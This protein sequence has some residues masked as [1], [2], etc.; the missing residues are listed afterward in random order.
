MRW[1]VLQCALT[2]HRTRRG[3]CASSSPDCR[4][5]R[6]TEHWSHDARSSSFYKALFA[7]TSAQIKVKTLIILYIGYSM[8]VTGPGNLCPFSRIAGFCVKWRWRSNVGQRLLGRPAKFTNH[9]TVKASSW[10]L[11]KWRD[12][13]SVGLINLLKGVSEWTNPT[14]HG[15]AHDY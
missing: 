11:A 1:D 9:T 2:I 12:V 8:C 3:Q 4:L 5:R 7:S 13:W 6:R 10:I 15:V 14:S